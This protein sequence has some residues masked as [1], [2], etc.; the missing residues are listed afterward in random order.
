VLP[1]LQPGLILHKPMSNYLFVAV[2]S[3]GVE[4][5]GK[6]EVSTQS[7]ALR[8]IREMGLFP[9]RVAA[10]AGARSSSRHPAIRAQA[11]PPPFASFS[12]FRL[13]RVK[14]THLTTFT[15]QLATLIEAGMP[16][17]RGLRIFREQEGSRRLK[18]VIE[19]LALRIENG[20]SLAEAVA[21]HPAVF[22]QLYVN[23]IRAGEI[24]G[25]LEA[26]LQRLAEFR[27]KSQRI[28]GKVKAAMFYP[29]AVLFVAVA[30]MTFLMIF[31]LPRFQQ[32][33]EELMNGARL[34]AFTL[35]VFG[36]SRFIRTHFLAAAGFLAASL[37]LFTMALRTCWG[38]F[39]FDRIKLGLPVFGPLFRKISISRFARTLGT[40]ISN[41]VPILQALSI[42]K[43]TAGN[44]CVGRLIETVHERVKQG[45][46][47]APTLKHSSLFP[48]MVVGMIDVGEQTGAL[49]Q[50]LMKIADTYDEEVDNAASALTS[51]IEP[52]M[53]VLLAVIVGSIVIAM[54]L[55]LLS[56]V[57]GEG[58]G[59]GRDN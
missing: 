50:M 27:E 38:R 25:A 17:L 43:E 21:A 30:I 8:R 18:R 11:V 5:R 48:R 15:R 37:A 58:I 28:R 9:T 47:I 10:E 51:L 39:V 46:P 12:R 2:D 16:L 22:D 20:S 36:V 26:A 19:D 57:N 32:I 7:E 1:C 29:C 6:L 41:G 34:P 13:R 56:V 24:G 54:F 45:E 40:L 44:V 3:Q 4:T 31:V 33:F 42:V 55:P 35:L 23:M 52:I 49:P 53:I 59:A 14:A